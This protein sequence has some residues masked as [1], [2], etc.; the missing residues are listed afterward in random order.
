MKRIIDAR[1]YNNHIKTQGLQFQIDNYYQP[2]EISMVRRVNVVLKELAPKQG[3]KILDAGCGVGTFAYHTAQI[4]SFSIGI[5]YSYE[6]IKMALE[7]NTKFNTSERSYFLVSNACI[8][9]FKDGFFDKVVSIDFIEHITFKDKKFFL[10]E[11]YRVLKPGGTAVI[12]T[13]NAIREKIG[14]IYWKCRRLIFRNNIPTTDLHF[15]LINRFQF[16]PLL[17]KHKFNFKL[18]YEDITRPY[19]ARLPLI[20]NILALNLLWILRKI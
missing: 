2:K 10:E 13:P 14:D 8:L 1:V 20:K 18:I 15:G 16:E 6:S 19:L 11:I 7:L 9:P 5:D 12:F 3:E 4:G 17:K